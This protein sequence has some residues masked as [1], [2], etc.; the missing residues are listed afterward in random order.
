MNYMKALIPFLLLLS[1]GIKSFSKD[2]VAVQVLDADILQDYFFVNNEGINITGYIKFVEVNQQIKD[3]VGELNFWNM[4]D[5]EGIKVDD[6]LRGN[7]SLLLVD[8]NNQRR[9]VEP[10]FRLSL[11]DKNGLYYD[12]EDLEGFYEFNI[13][14]NNI[15]EGIYSLRW[16]ISSNDYKI[17]AYLID[18]DGFSPDEIKIKLPSNKD[19]K[20]KLLIQKVENL[21]RKQKLYANE[22]SIL[23]DLESTEPTDNTRFEIISNL[24]VEAEEQGKIIEALAYWLVLA[25]CDRM[26]KSPGSIVEKYG[27][28]DKVLKD[29]SKIEKLFQEY[30]GKYFKN[31]PYVKSP[32]DLKYSELYRQ[33]IELQKLYDEGDED[34]LPAKDI[35]ALY[36]KI[37][38]FD[39]KKEEYEK[40]KE[41]NLNYYNILHIH[42][43]MLSYIKHK[44]GIFPEHF[45]TPR[46]DGYLEKDEFIYFIPDLSKPRIRTKFLYRGGMKYQENGKDYVLAYPQAENGKRAVMLTSGDVVEVPEDEFLKEAEKQGFPLK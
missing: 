15:P 27:G 1:V 31:L 25:R 2:V 44:N 35:E 30:M 14:T 23:A 13:N 33:S 11:V 3:K 4:K 39:R 29:E 37:R 12:L 26:G 8:N 18:E 46:E 16:K 5:Y 21:R 41:R 45:F 17:V 28:W 7:L 36:C 32:Q 24:R 34:E 22:E 10:E 20:N 40:I 43:E 19:D 42:R 38:N 9:L 6:G